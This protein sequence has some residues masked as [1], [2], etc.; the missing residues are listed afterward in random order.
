MYEWR[1]MT[2]AERAASLA[3]RQKQHFPWH[4][5]P[6]LDL[7]GEKIY[8]LTSSCYEH[9]PIIGV[10]SKRLGECEHAILELCESCCQIFAW[11][12]LPSHYHL[13][14]R[15]EQIKELRRL[16]GLWHGRSSRAWNLE[17]QRTGRKVWFNCFERVLKSKGHFY[18]SLNYV[19][20]NPV[21]HGLVKHW[22]DWPFSSARLFL[23]TVGRERAKSIWR[24]YPLL[25]YGDK[26]DV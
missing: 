11:C 20:H 3:V 9:Q 21:K 12:V 7:E 10:S 6:H 26:W 24:D 18:A 8:L 25:E 15:T 17:E 2:P 22:Q 19:H 16:L 13:L 23:K 1:K 5:P 14:L 4:S